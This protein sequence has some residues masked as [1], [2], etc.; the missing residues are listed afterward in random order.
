[1]SPRME[2]IPFGANIFMIGKVWCGMAMNLVNMG[3]P[4][5]AW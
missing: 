3:R 5:I 4:K 1:M 2:R